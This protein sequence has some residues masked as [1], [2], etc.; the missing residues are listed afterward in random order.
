MSSQKKKFVLAA[1]GILTCVFGYVLYA[2]RRLFMVSDVTSGESTAYPDLRSHVY[3][4]E[5]IAALQI[6]VQT[7]KQL[8]RWRV[9]HIDS[10]L[11]SIEAEVESMVGRLLDD[12]TVTIEKLGDHRVR[13]TIRS[14]SRQG[15]GD[16]GQNAQH[17]RVLQNDMD[18][19]L[20]TWAAF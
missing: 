11:F 10:E 17:I 8:P 19:K 7:I 4:A 18:A 1:T 14:R 5:P 16:L 6:A 13:A 15:S 20:N 12:V 2:N 3:Y 9:V